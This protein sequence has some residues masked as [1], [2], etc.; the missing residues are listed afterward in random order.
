MQKLCQELA[1]DQVGC[2]VV[3][4]SCINKP[5]LECLKASLAKTSGRLITVEDHQ[6]VGGMGSVLTHVLA[7]E[8]VDFKLKSLGV[9]GKFGQSAYTASDLYEKHGIDGRAIEVTTK[10]FF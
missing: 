1:K 7:C 6:V 9:G 3:N 4:S 10:D 8:G 5:D 2:L